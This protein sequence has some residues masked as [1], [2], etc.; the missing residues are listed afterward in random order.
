MS[1]F[2]IFHVNLDNAPQRKAV[3]TL[4]TRSLFY[5]IANVLFFSP[6]AQ[7][8]QKTPPWDLKHQGPKT[9]EIAALAKTGE[10]KCGELTCGSSMRWL[11]IW[12][13]CVS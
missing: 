3:M 9:R 6:F 12:M 10:P 8:S 13:G 1:D 5:V 4:L 7:D 11:R 2:Y